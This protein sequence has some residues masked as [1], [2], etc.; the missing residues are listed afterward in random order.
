MPIFHSTF[1][2]YNFTFHS[3]ISRKLLIVLVAFKVKL[4]GKKVY[5]FTHELMALID[6]LGSGHKVSA[7][8]G[9][10]IFQKSSKKINVPILDSYSLIHGPIARTGIFFMAP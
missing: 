6:L 4:L 3:N 1:S 7:I 9:W 2:K 10:M 5:K 8:W